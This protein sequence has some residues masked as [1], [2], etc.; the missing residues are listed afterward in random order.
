MIVC[1]FTADHGNMLAEHGKM[2][3]GRPYRTAAGIPFIV[4]Y[5]G[6]VPKGKVVKTAY[7]S[8]DFVPSILN[9]MNVDDH[10]LQLDGVVFTDEMLNDKKVTNSKKVRFTFDT[11][12]SPVWAA[13]ISQQYKL[14]VSGMDVPW[15]FDLDMDP[16]EIHNYFDEPS[17]LEERNRLLSHLFIALE[18]H[19]IP[20]YEH[21]NFMYWSTP[22]CVDSTDRI[23]TWGNRAITCADLDASS[24]KCRKAKFKELCPLSCGQ[25]KKKVR[26]FCPE[27]C[28]SCGSSN[29]LHDGNHTYYSY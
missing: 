5:P 25:C 28:S 16:F 11:G 10:N 3:K 15:L 19:D 22:Y 7:S 14:V 21:V 23:N 9:L 12:R 18:K 2:K 27:V 20:L 6:I 1:S 4:R 24:N 29:G 13:A 17:H 8:I 26:T